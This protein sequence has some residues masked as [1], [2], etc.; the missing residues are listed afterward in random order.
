MTKAADR[1]MQW[2]R[3]AHAMEKQAEQMLSGLASRIKHYPAL[4]ARIEEHIEETRNQARMVERCIEARG[5][6]VSSLKDMA[7]QFLATAQA[8]SG[9]FAGD[10]IMK[11]SLAG[12]TFEHME[13]ASYRIIIAAAEAL[14]D[15]QTAMTCRQILAEEEAMAEWLAD[16]IG[17]LTRE[18]L[19]REENRY[20][21]AK[22]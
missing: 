17:S 3:D 20:A 4:K 10:E 21:E 7:G 19:D 6:D 2:L 14:G 9:I 12:Y 13:I 18:F 11:G 8:L 22:R 16:N 15:Q 1:L 5:S